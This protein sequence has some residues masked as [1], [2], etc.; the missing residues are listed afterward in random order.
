LPPP[1]VC[2]LRLPVDGSDATYYLYIY[3]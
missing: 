1:P 2:S 3:K